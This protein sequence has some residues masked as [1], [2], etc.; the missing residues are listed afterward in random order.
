MANEGKF[1]CSLSGQGTKIHLDPEIGI[2]SKRCQKG[3][4]AGTDLV[5]HG[6][7]GV[8][9]QCP[10]VTMTSSSAKQCL[11]AVRPHG[12][13][14]VMSSMGGTWSWSGCH[15]CLASGHSLNLVCL[16]NLLIQASM[17][18]KNSLLSQ[19]SRGLLLAT[20]G[21]GWPIILLPVSHVWHLWHHSL[22]ILPNPDPLYSNFSLA[23][24]FSLCWPLLF[25][26]YI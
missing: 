12:T 6:S 21:P 23:S 15:G 1:P 5:S 24:D 20:K 18:Y 10:V 26:I 3:S 9:G 8:Q 25:Y 7:H 19:R 2:K 16:P 22:R 11:R 4:K 17:N 13:A 14:A